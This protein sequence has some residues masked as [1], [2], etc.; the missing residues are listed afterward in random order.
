VGVRRFCPAGRN[1]RRHQPLFRL[2]PN[3]CCQAAQARIFYDQRIQTIREDTPISIAQRQDTESAA[4]FPVTQDFADWVAALS[5]E[6]IP[7]SAFAWARHALLDW[8]AVTIAAQ[9]EPLVEMLV[10]ECAGSED[11]PCTLV[12]QGRRARPLE[13]ALINGSASHALDYDD[14]NRRLH[15]HPTVCMAGAALALGEALKASGRDVLAAFIAGT[16]VGCN[17][18]EMSDEGHYEAGYHATGTMGTFGAAA[19]AARL[20]RLDAERTA[21]AFGIAASQAS[22]LKCNFGT[23]TKP[24]HAGKGAMNGLLAA[25][26]AARGFT[27][28]TGAV[29]APQGFADTQVPG[30]DGGPVRPDPA[31]AFA[32][33]GTLFKYHAACYLTHAC[34]EAIGELREKHGVTL[35]GIETATLYFRPT[36][37]SVCCIPAP[38]T[39]LEI[40]FSIAHLAAMALDGVDTAALESYSNANANNHRYVAAREEKVRMEPRDEIDR[41]AGL[42][43]VEMKDGRKLEEAGDVGKPAR[44]LDAQWDRLSAKFAALTHPVIGEARANAL[45]DAIA[46][47][48]DAADLKALMEA[49]R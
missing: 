19:A 44:D 18:G 7:E 31:R 16:E 33:E 32:V 14:V 20:M 5:P 10:A 40:K 36:H 1:S 29:E 48:G 13:A 26:L 49:A 12:G 11:D 30:F 15:G 27:A 43:M 47:L 24:L 35:D 34:L 23:M 3:S 2:E 9:R 6:D 25:R 46:G 8:F 37:L 45:R 4:T 28:N 21:R 39:G 41:L 42:V 17:L 22:G 38:K